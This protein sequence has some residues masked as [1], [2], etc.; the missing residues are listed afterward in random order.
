MGKAAYWHAVFDGWT[1][2]ETCWPAHSLNTNRTHIYQGKISQGTKEPMAHC[3]TSPHPVK[4]YQKISGWTPHSRAVQCNVTHHICLPAQR[5]PAAHMLWILHTSHH[6][7]FW[8]IKN[9]IEKNGQP[10]TH[11]IMN[12]HWSKNKSNLNQHPFQKNMFSVFSYSSFF[13]DIPR[14]YLLKMYWLE[15]L[16]IQQYRL[17]CRQMQHS[18]A[19]HCIVLCLHDRPINNIA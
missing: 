3:L 10:T 19:C 6:G 8:N 16:V 5:Q 13:N 12:N 1:K 4:R 17:E 14:C 7:Q 15:G 2:F 9:H 18:A 11:K